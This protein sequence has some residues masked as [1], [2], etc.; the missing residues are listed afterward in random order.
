M[1]TEQF[2]A[3]NG[4]R[5]FQ[6]F[7]IHLADGRLFTVRHQE[8]ASTSQSGRTLSVFSDDNV[9]EVIDLLLVTSLRPLVLRLA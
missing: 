6:P 1:T 2:R 5:P 3:F 4:A 8:V 7:A 9:Q